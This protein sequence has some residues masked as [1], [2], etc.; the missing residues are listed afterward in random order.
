MVV[1]GALALALWAEVRV[2]SADPHGL[3]RG[4]TPPARQALTPIH[5]ELCLILAGLAEQIDVGFVAERR[6]ARLD[7]VLK[8][9][10]EGPVP[11]PHLLGR[12]RVRNPVVAKA[13]REQHLVGVD[14]AKSRD[15]LLV[16]HELFHLGGPLREQV[17][18][19]LPCEDL[20][21][22]IDR[23]VL[24]L[25]YPPPFVPGSDEEL[26][27]RSRIDE[28]QVPSLLERDD[29]MGVR[30][31]R[32]ASRSTL[33][34]S[35][36]PERRNEHAA[37]VK[38]QQKVFPPSLDLRNL[39]AHEA[40]AEVLP[41]CMP[42][43]HSHRVLR[44]LDL[45]ILDPAADHVPFEVAAHDFD[46]R[47]LHASPSGIRSLGALDDPRVSLA[48]R[49]LLGLFLRS[50]GSS[51][52]T[53][54]GEEDRCGDDLLVFGSH[55]LQPIFGH[56]TQLLRGNLLQERLEVAVSLSSGVRLHSGAEQTL[57][58]L[59]CNGKASVQIDGSEDGLERVCQD[60]RLVAPAA[61]FLS[62]AQEHDRADVERPSDVRERGHVHDGSAQLR[63]RPLRKIGEQPV[64]EIGHDEAQHGVTEELESLV[65]DL[66]AI[67]E[68]IRTVRDRCLSESGVTKHHAERSVE[69]LQG[70]RPPHLGHPVTRPRQ[71]DAPRSIRSS[72]TPDAGAWAGGTAGTRNTQERR[73]SS[74]PLAFRSLTSPASSSERPC[75][76]YLGR[77]SSSCVNSEPSAAHR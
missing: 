6:A 22:R 63:Q 46:F 43:D 3:D 55:L 31:E 65:R 5:L 73:S 24:E 8:R 14:V 69:R 52:H 9:L 26:S 42:A 53:L 23:K 25:L 57:D 49:L 28:T 64:G 35:A 12:E 77:E 72:R 75:P 58:E 36:H 27:K 18:E 59:A 50:T 33:K 54:A 4:S 19:R 39:A 62:L 76:T 66:E 70:Q 60:A 47:K 38:G 1:L 32:H 20:V 40:S 44:G 71:P 16:H 34:L 2:A 7:R 56:R 51:A 37:R 10:L 74:S 67:L 11:A 61:L 30:G 15:E 13:R 29:H 21:E 68:R 48:G 41:L 45:R 17:L